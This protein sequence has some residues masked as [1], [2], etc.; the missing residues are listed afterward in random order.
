MLTFFS[1][2][3]RVISRRRLSEEKNLQRKTH[4]LHPLF[5][6]ASFK[7]IIS[8]YNLI[9]WKY[10]EISLSMHPWQCNTVQWELQWNWNWNWKFAVHTKINFHLS[11]VKSFILCQFLEKMYSTCA[12]SLNLFLIYRK[13]TFHIWT[14]NWL[15][16]E[17]LQC[18]CISNKTVLLTRKTQHTFTFW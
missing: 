2:H 12:F 3:L 11:L 8:F 14:L 1:C 7:F 5:L 17:R 6:K 15:M 13:I 10:K 18:D 9:V 4:W 16:V